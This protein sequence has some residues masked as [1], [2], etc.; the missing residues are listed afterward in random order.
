MT[1]QMEENTMKK[2]LQRLVAL[3]ALAVF[4]VSIVPLVAADEGVRADTRAEA[5]ASA[6]TATGVPTREVVREAREQVH[7][8][9]RELKDAR[10]TVRDEAKERRE[11]GNETKAERRGKMEEIK[12]K[13]K[14]IREEYRKAKKDHEESRREWQED[15]NKLHDLKQAA[16]CKDDTDACK[17]KKT[18]LK[19]GVKQH[20]LKTIDVIDKSLQ[21]LLSRVDDSKT[22]TDEEKQQ[23]KTTITDLETSLTAQKEKVQALAETAT[24][25]EV[26]QAIQDLKHAWQDIRTEQ[27]RIISTLMKNQLEGI[28]HKHDEYQNAMKMKID[29]L[30]AKGVDTTELETLYQHFV[31][32]VAELKAKQAIAVEK[33]Q[34][35]QADK[36]KLQE[37]KEAQEDVRNQLVLTKETLREFM[38]K[39]RD[40]KKAGHLEVEASTE[41]STQAATPAAEASTESSTVAGET[42]TDASASA[43]TT[44]QE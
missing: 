8:K 9:V 2:I 35:A 39:F 7:E 41:A 15:K 42:N 12:D 4:I 43:G 29:Q 33:W 31:D 27:R 30:K 16:A 17:E 20:L 26:R 11:Q 21:Q 19:R 5:N 10:E 28:V 22:L 40:L 1:T 44:A 3:A 14:N 23:A 34:Q 32:Q 37:W 36:T 38:S 18:E 6:D 24:N 13:I 25:E